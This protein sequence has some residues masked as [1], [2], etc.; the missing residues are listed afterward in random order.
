M[1]QPSPYQRVYDLSNDDGLDLRTQVDVELDDVARCFL[2]VISNLSLIQRDD[3]ALANKS[4]GVEQLKAELIGGFNPPEPYQPYRPYN[5][6]DSFV[7]ADG[8]WMIVITPF[9]GD[10]EPPENGDPRVTLVY[11]LGVT[12]DAVDARDAAQIAQAAAELA[13]D[14][15]QTAATSASS[16]AA[17]TAGDRQAAAGSAATASS[18][19]TIATDAADA[20]SLGSAQA[21]SAA[22]TA[23][24][25]ADRAQD[26]V[27][28]FA[29]GYTGFDE[30]TGYDFGYVTREVTYF[31]RDFG[32]LV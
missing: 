24:S 8:R 10:L 23:T 4:V 26:T 9:T 3:G 25:Q 17:Q 29:A 32:G 2:E 6:N 28:Q 22:T 20:A 12:Q 19:A 7:T 27:D 30:A 15:A 1:S 11:D 5:T 16:D 21:Q 14:Q 31:D 13:R 18:Q